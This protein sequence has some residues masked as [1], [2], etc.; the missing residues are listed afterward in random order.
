VV[1][2]QEDSPEP[3]KKAKGLLTVYILLLTAIGGTAKVL[4]S[5]RQIFAPTDVQ[6]A[7]AEIIGAV[8]W[9]DEATVSRNVRSPLAGGDT[10]KVLI[11]RGQASN[12]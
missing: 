6:V 1:K 2:R 12:P 9:G 10:V 4:T 8:F 11:T 7:A 3:F 5:L